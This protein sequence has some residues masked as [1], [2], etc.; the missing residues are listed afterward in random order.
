[1][2]QTDLGGNSTSA[3]SQHHDFNPS[4]LCPAACKREWM[5]PHP[6][7]GRVDEVGW[8]RLPLA[9]CLAHTRAP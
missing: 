4:E 8:D 5:K 9:L 6:E 7:G 2:S 1:M 3:T